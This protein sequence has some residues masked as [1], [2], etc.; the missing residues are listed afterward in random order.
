MTVN[1]NSYGVNGGLLGVNIGCPIY[2]C[3]NC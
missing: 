1:D 3:M 2:R